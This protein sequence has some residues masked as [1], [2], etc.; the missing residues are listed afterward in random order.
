LKISTDLTSLKVDVSPARDVIVENIV[1][2]GMAS[3]REYRVAY[4]REDGSSEVPDPFA[5]QIDPS[6]VTS[7]DGLKV[8]ELILISKAALQQAP[9]VPYPDAKAPL[10][11]GTSLEFFGEDYM[12]SAVSGTVIF[13]LSCADF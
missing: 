13:S 8:A 9:F 11:L 7:G 10:R 1:L 5:V 2:Q 12:G 4:F 6:S 3:V